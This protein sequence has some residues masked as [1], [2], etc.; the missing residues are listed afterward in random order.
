MRTSLIETEQIEAHLMQRSE[1]G[2]QLVFEA[3][4]LLEPELGEKMQWQQEAYRMVKLYG[5][6]QL[7]QD[8]EAV[9]LKLFTQKEHLS[10][11][12]KIRRLFNNR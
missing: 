8:I 5:R 11:S 2:D 4:L 12:Q 10:F 9:H 7:K 1:P 3:M 6:D